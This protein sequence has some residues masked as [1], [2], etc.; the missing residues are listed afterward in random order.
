LPGGSHDASPDRRP[1]AT[2]PPRSSPAADPR[3]RRRPRLDGVGYLGGSIFTGGAT[4]GQTATSSRVTLWDLHARYTPGRWDLSGV[5][6]RGTISN[7]AELNAPLVG[8]TTLI[9]ASF[10]GWYGQAAYRTWSTADYSLV[11]GARREARYVV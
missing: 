7:T 8:G 4:H 1:P 11:P 5:Y 10:D 3:S 2:I 9:P 6:S